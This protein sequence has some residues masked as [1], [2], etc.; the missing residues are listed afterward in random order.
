MSARVEDVEALAAAFGADMG[1]VLPNIRKITT[2]ATREPLP[3]DNAAAGYGIGSRWVWQGLEWALANLDGSVARWVLV[4]DVTPEMFGAGLTSD[5][6]PAFRLAIAFLTARGGGVLRLR[7]KTY[8]FASTETRTVIS[9]GSTAWDPALSAAYCVF[10]PAGVSIVGTPGRSKIEVTVG[11]T[12]GALALR[13]WGNA[14]ISGLEIEGAGTSTDQH[15]ISFVT[16]SQDHV[17]SDFE[18]SDL[19]IHNVGSYGIGYQYGLP[20]RA[21]VRDIYIHDTG[22]DGIDWKVRGSSVAASF[23]QGVVFDNIEV[24]RFGL[25]LP[26]SS[27]TGIGL[28]GPAQANNIRV[29]EIGPG[30]VGIAFT[31]GIATATNRDYRISSHRSSLTNWYAEGARQASGEPPVGLD[32]FACGSVEIGPGVAHRCIVTST[33]PTAT[34]YATLHGPRIR[35]TIIPPV[36]VNAAILRVPGASA[37]LVVQSDYDL[38]STKAGNAT[39]GQTVFSAAAGHGPFLRVVRDGATLVAGTDYS[40]SGDTVTLA[41]GLPSGAALFLVY[42]PLR[43]VRVEA[44]YQTITGHADR[45]CLNGVSYAAQSHVDTSSALGFVWDAMLSRLA[46]VNSNSVTGLAAAGAGNNALRLTGS[47]T[48]PV[49]VSRPAFIN[50]PTSAAGLSS[51]AVWHDVAANVLRPAP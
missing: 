13:D 11:G 42:P 39:A 7:E 27:S 31:P 12:G 28:R 4:S 6:A 24:R 33:A 8:T 1:R 23:A 51:G 34:P 22:S 45:W 29:Y 32:V 17:C 25:R 9:V 2:D 18:L 41:T 15:G 49:E 44:G 35:A 37:D 26:G 43:A 16:T 5:D 20:V 19:H 10:V 46:P 3:T 14:R 50:L 40:L 38:F 30:Q 36:N 21:T 48:A 47:G